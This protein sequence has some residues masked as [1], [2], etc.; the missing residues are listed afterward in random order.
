MTESGPKK[1]N[2]L[3]KLVLDS[4]P[5]FCDP[6]VCCPELEANCCGICTNFTRACTCCPVS[7]SFR[8]SSGTDQKTTSTAETKVNPVSCRAKSD[9]KST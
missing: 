9:V 2:L 6:S 8:T 3:S 1:T 5:T 4:N 7:N